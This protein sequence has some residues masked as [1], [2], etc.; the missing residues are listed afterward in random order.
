MWQNNGNTSNA[1]SN[2]CRKKYV[3]KKSSYKTDLSP[4]GDLSIT[5]R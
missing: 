1:V 4:I 2:G 3:L 5:Y